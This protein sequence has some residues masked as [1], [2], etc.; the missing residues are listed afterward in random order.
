MLCVTCNVY[1]SVYTV[2]KPTRGLVRF[3]QIQGVETADYNFFNMYI[4]EI[5]SVALQHLTVIRRGVRPLSQF[6]ARNCVKTSVTQRM[7][8]RSSRA[9]IYY[10]RMTAIPHDVLARTPSKPKI[11]LQ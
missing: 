3:G 2:H 7:D 1:G 8:S 5:L 6:G 10:I 4:V 11:V 9:I